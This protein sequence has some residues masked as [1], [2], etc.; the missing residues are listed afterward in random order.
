MYSA[1][2]GSIYDNAINEFKNGSKLNRN[3][4]S[5]EYYDNGI[6]KLKEGIDKVLQNPKYE[7][8]NTPDWK[9]WLTKLAI[10]ESAGDPTVTN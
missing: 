4:K 9:E 8:F 7:K 1:E 3:K 10:R 5:K 2:V 6:R